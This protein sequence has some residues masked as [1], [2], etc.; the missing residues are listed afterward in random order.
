MLNLIFPMLF[1]IVGITYYVMKII[2]MGNKKEK[3]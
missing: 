3:K 2:N 1:Y